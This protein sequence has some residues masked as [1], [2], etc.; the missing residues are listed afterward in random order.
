MPIAD[1]SQ[2]RQPGLLFDQKS[3]INPTSTLAGLAP[4]MAWPNL[5]MFMFPDRNFLDY[6]AKQ[7]NDLAGL[8]MFQ[9]T[10]VSS[11]LDVSLN[12]ADFSNRDVIS[13]GPSAGLG[14]S[15]GPD[16]MFEDGSTPDGSFTIAMVLSIDARALLKDSYLWSFRDNMNAN[17]TSIGYFDL[18]D[19]AL[20]FQPASTS[21]FL[22]LAASSLPDVDTAFWLAY[23]YDYDTQVGRLWI[24]D[25]T[26]PVATVT[27]TARPTASQWRHFRLGNLE[28]TPD[29]SW[30]GKFGSIAMKSDVW[31]DDERTDWSDWAQYYVVSDVLGTDGFLLGSARLGF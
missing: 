25:P 7:D 10:A 21:N 27:H 4:I 24:N 13:Y 18:S 23:D 26:T 30:I 6:S 12:D 16:L 14:T 15:V 5:F 3:P 9:W 22:T 29:F 31:T 1:F 17:V 20:K 19:N 8:R 28:G 11:E 2:A